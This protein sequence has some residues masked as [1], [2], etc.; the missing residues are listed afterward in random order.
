M[1]KNNLC[2]TNVDIKSV[3]P[4][5]VKTRNALKETVSLAIEITAKNQEEDAIR[6][7]DK[8][9]QESEGQLE[10]LK[11][12][13]NSKTEKKK[14]DLLTLQ[15]ESRSIMEGGRANAEARALATAN[16]IK[17]E[18]GLELA[19]L[20][21]KAQDTLFTAE[22]FRDNEVHRV[23]LSHQKFMSDL[24]IHHEK[25]MSEVEANKFEQMIGTLGKETL[26]AIANSGM[27]SKVAMLEGL[28][29][30]GYLLTDGKS[31][32]NLFN[33]ANGMV[34]KK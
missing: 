33:A 14:M 10:R 9:K 31:P 24:R 15:A 1:E 19:N 32:I 5:D 18:T 34:E 12:D 4:I 16:L 2:L 20:K 7:S 26:V 8:S 23:K 27:E 22:A 11:I 17:T 30:K 6:Q 29:L 13:Y 3:E 21:S 25:E 28:G